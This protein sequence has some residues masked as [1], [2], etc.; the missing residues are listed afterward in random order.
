MRHPPP[1]DTR[2]KATWVDKG[3]RG[4]IQVNRSIRT[5]PVCTCVEIKEVS[6]IYHIEDRKSTHLQYLNYPPQTSC[7]KLGNGAEMLRVRSLRCNTHMSRGGARYIFGRSYPIDPDVNDEFMRYAPA[8]CH[9]SFGNFGNRTPENKRREGRSIVNIKRD[10]LSG[11]IQSPRPK[12]GRWRQK[13]QA[14]NRIRGRQLLRTKRDRSKI[15]ENS[16]EKTRRKHSAPL[17]CHRPSMQ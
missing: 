9:H 12:Q 8:N 4:G 2:G 7:E 15:F 10:A 13:L 5:S 1:R 3:K 16:A 17:T 11:Q 14:V 6:C